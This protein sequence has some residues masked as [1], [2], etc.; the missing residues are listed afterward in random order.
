LDYDDVEEDEDNDN[1][2]VNLNSSHIDEV[3][4]DLIIEE[5]GIH[6]KNV[7]GEVLK[8]SV[9]GSLNNKMKDIHIISSPIS[10]TSAVFFWLKSKNP[11]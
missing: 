4:L 1:D 8:E 5:L 9:I 2:G 10:Q 7:L 3:R 6:E 11:V